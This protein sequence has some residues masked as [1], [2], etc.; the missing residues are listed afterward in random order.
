MIVLTTIEVR[1]EY[2]GDVLCYSDFGYEEQQCISYDIASH[3]SCMISDGEKLA[4]CL[5]YIYNSD[6]QSYYATL[7]DL[8]FLRK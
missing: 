4:S 1:A 7:P 3:I 2:K 5:A 6:C 8:R